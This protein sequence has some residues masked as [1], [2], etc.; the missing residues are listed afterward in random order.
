MS[1]DSSVEELR[2]M[3]AKWGQSPS[4]SATGSA[5]EQKKETAKSSTTLIRENEEI[6][7]DLLKYLFDNK[8]KLQMQNRLTV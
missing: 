7:N 4:T 2:D 8:E 3:S 5:A 6:K 1:S